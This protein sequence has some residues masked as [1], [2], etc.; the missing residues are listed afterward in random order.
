MEH[1]EQTN[2]DI[3]ET[4]ELRD[5]QERNGD[6]PDEELDQKIAQ[7]KDLKL[8]LTKAIVQERSTEQ[9]CDL[10]QFEN[11]NFHAIIALNKIDAYI[12]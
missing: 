7:L 9:I 6:A 1:L 11:Q 10:S 2:E 5:Y 8:R 4:M 12:S 3:A